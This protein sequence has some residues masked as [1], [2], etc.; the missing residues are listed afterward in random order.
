MKF[1]RPLIAIWV[2]TLFLPAAGFA[3]TYS[4]IDYPGAT[5]TFAYGVNATGDVVGGYTASFVN[6]GFLLK[7]GVY[8]SVDFPGAYTTTASA[9]NDSG[10]IVGSF[11]NGLVTHGFIVRG[12]T[13]T[14]LDYPDAM[15]TRPYAINDNGDIV[16]EYDDRNVKT[17]GF[18]WRNGVFTS[19]DVAPNAFTRITGINNNGD[20][21]GNVFLFGSRRSHY[22]NFRISNGTV[23]MIVAPSGYQFGAAAGGINDQG[24]AVSSVMFGSATSAVLLNATDDFTLLQNQSTLQPPYMVA[25]GINNNG[26]IVGWFIDAPYTAHGFIA[27]N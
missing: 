13:Y 10:D 16:G 21:Y 25:E 18:E 27:A 17:H 5:A 14:K 20:M 4:T 1:C 2:L 6:H 19:I 11:N 3:V 26:V 15:N 12:T 8:T 22:R 7:N 24:Q 9:I 23:E